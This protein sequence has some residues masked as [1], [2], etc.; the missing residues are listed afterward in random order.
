MIARMVNNSRESLRGGIQGGRWY[1]CTVMV[2]SSNHT[3]LVITPTCQIHSDHMDL[4]QSTSA[5]LCV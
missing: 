1:C 3:T 4:K 2:G 5:V